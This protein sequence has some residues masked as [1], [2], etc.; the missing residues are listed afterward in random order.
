VFPGQVQ[1]PLGSGS[2]ASPITGETTEV[3]TNLI[4]LVVD[5]LVPLIPETKEV[6]VLGDDLPG[7]PQRT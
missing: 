1:H 6:V 2:R 5:A 4:G 7:L 3:L